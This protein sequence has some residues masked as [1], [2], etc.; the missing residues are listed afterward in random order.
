MKPILEPHKIENWDE[1]GGA[2]QETQMGMCTVGS[3]DPKPF[4]CSEA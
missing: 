2:V 1:C 3:S 4:I